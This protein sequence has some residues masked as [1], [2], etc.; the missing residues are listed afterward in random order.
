MSNIHRSRSLD[1]VRQRI[2]QIFDSEDLDGGGIG[3]SDELLRSQ[4]AAAK[5]RMQKL[6]NIL[7]HDLDND[8]AVSVE[9]LRRSLLPQARRPLRSTAGS[10][11][12]TP[13]QVAETLEALV[14]K[15]E[16]PDRDGDG[17]ATIAEIIAAATAEFEAKV[18]RTRRTQIGTVYDLNGDGTVT[19]AEFETVFETVIPIVDSDGDGL[20]SDAEAKAFRSFVSEAQKRLRERA[21]EEARRAELRDRAAA[22]PIPGIPA[23]AEIVLLSIVHSPFRAMVTFGDANNSTYFVDVRIEEGE[24]PIHLILAPGAR[25]I[26]RFSGAVD[27]LTGVFNIGQPTMGFVGIDRE[28]AGW[29]ERPVCGI[30]GGEVSQAGGHAPPVLDYVEALAGRKPDRIIGKSNV[31]T[32]LVPSGRLIKPAQ[33][34]VENE[35]R[36]G[37]S[38]P[39]WKGVPR[40]Q[41]IP[42]LRMVPITIDNIIAPVAVR[43]YEEPN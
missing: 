25:M 32:I 22:C 7:Q 9:E 13:E 38:G 41:P 36:E 1:E 27:R 19:R 8:G 11:T 24:T 35:R 15:L 31:A 20:V 39:T 37:L 2:L 29:F 23:N 40:D 17:R 14:Q 6:N 26:L 5:Y 30:R 18:S 43:P 28:I 21:Q 10:I 4:Q 33:E 42:P 34:Q 16:L 12:P 3:Q